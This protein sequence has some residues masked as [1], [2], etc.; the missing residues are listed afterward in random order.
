V[1]LGALL[2]WTPL[3]AAIPKA[4]FRG[5]ARLRYLLVWSAGTFVMFS[6]I[7]N[8]L[9]GYLLPLLPPLAALAGI[10]LAA[11]PIPRTA[12]VA[13]AAA[14]VMLPLAERVLPGALEHG[15]GTAWANAAIPPVWWLLP[16]LAAGA[17]WVLARRSASAAIAFLGAASFC[18]WAYLESATFP[19]IDRQAGTRQLWRE[20]RPHLS[21]TCIGDVRR[22]V[23]YG[24]QYYSTGRLP[25]CENAPRP[26]RVES[27]PAVINRSVTA[28]IP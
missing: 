18:G 21:S 28:I 8:K 13:T 11:T 10:R 7:T 1:L 15:L 5:D 4:D 25:L 3:L 6:V 19:A 27:D 26:V 2:P 12:L 9:P 24:L 23:E 22:H 17:T 14:W 16:P 20:I